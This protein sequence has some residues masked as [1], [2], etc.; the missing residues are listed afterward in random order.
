LHRC[1]L[2]LAARRLRPDSCDADEG[3]NVL[4][5][6]RPRPDAGRAGR[7][8]LAGVGPKATQAFSA[9]LNVSAAAA[10]GVQQK[11]HPQPA[12]RRKPVRISRA[13]A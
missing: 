12:R 13:S 1:G 2:C 10:G 6:R 5:G 11:T 3:R 7:R 9:V 4:R 8:C